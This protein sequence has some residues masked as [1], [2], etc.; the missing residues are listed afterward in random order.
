MGGELNRETQE[1]SEGARKALDDGEL[2]TIRRICASRDWNR[3]W[4]FV[5]ERKLAYEQEGMRVIVP[6]PR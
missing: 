1:A 4:A 3:E 2:R 6:T 5:D